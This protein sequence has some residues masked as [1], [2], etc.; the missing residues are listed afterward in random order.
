MMHDLEIGKT[1][2]EATALRDR[3][4][5]MIPLGRYARPGEAAAVVAF[6]AS[7]DSS[8]I[9]GAAIPVDGGLKAQ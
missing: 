2:E 5:A 8:F 6:L 7:D 9:N 1:V 3:F 4:T